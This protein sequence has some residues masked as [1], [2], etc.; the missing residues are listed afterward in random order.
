VMTK[1]VPGGFRLNSHKRAPHTL[2]KSCDFGLPELVFVTSAILNF[3]SLP[4][5]DWGKI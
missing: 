5:S 2:D 4:N 3:N 1:S